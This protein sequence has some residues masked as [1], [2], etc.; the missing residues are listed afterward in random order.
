[1]VA[2]ENIKAGDKVIS[3][4]PDTGVTEE[5]P[6]LEAFSRSVTELVHLTVSVEEIITTH[7][8]PFFVVGKGFVNAG[9]LKLGDMVVSN[10][11]EKLSITDI[12][13]ESTEQPTTVYNFK[14][15]DYH[16][17]YVGEN[18]VF[19]HNANCRLIE[20]PDGSYDAEMSYKEDWTPEQRA[21]ADAKCK[22]LSEADT[23]KT[24]VAGKRNPNNTS[25][26][27]KDN[28][29]PSSQ[30]VDHLIDLQLNGKDVPSNM[31]GL[32]SSVNRSLGSQISSLI[33]NLPVGTVLRNFFMR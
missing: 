14:V 10:N 9:S 32:D 30:D 18:R 2:I 24:S 33:R 4:N 13:F 31:W 23:R 6:V 20:N 5:K 1:M 28:S 12:G 15:E 7:N 26:F 29:I 16:T 8:H 27:R 11:G 19:V 22:A 21:E 3:T 17:Y 25:R